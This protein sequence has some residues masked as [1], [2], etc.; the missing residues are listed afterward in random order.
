MWYDLVSLT[1]SFTWNKVNAL[2][3]VGEKLEVIPSSFSEFSS[4]FSPH[5]FGQSLISLSLSKISQVS[6]VPL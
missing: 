3:V 6:L 5:I 2:P 1:P 4:F